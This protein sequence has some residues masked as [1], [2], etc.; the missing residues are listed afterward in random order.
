MGITLEPSISYPLTLCVL[1]IFER[2]P[3]MQK[4]ISR[5]LF[6]FPAMFALMVI[7]VGCNDNNNPLGPYNPEITNITDSFQIQATGV[8]SLTRTLTYTW[9]NTG[10]VANVNHSTT[11]ISGSAKLTILDSSG[12][13]VYDKNL[14]PSL[15]EPT[16]SGNSGAW[17]INLTLTNY[18]GTLNFRVQNP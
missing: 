6:S 1:T 2:W 4:Y 7:F 11:T 8:Q 18:S 15:N 10:P 16:A 17:K 14:V 13:V 12:T 5:R 9:K 3:T